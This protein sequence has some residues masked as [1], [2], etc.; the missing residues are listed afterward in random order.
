MHKKLEK[1]YATCVT[2]ENVFKACSKYLENKIININRLFV[3]K[4]I[5]II[6]N[7]LHQELHHK[8]LLFYFENVGRKFEISSILLVKKNAILNVIFSITLHTH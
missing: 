3:S 6:I 1:S 4:L 2:R 5:I 7:F 8:K